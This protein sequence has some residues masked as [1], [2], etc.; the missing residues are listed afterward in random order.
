LTSKKD[1]DNHII[2]I[3]DPLDAYAFFFLHTVFT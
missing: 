2:C 3:Q 1:Y